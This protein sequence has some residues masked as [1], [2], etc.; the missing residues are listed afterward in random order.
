ME[1]LKDS[2]EIYNYNAEGFINSK[3]QFREVM[4]KKIRDDMRKKYQTAFKAYISGDW[5]QAKQIFEEILRFS[6]QDVLSQRIYN[7]IS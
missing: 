4:K 2:T 6:K 1:N 3:K 7:Y 5:A